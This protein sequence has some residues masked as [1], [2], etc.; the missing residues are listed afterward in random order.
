VP[1][2]SCK[3]ISLG[4]RRLR[5][6]DYMLRDSLDYTGTYTHTHTHTH[7]HSQNWRC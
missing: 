3:N 2:K 6:E 4:T 5:Q 7:T 1:N